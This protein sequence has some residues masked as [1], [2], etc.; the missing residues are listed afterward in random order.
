[1]IRVFPNAHQLPP[2]ISTTSFIQVKMPLLNLLFSLFALAVAFAASP[3]WAVPSDRRAHQPAN[4]VARA[5]MPIPSIA[6]GHHI[7]NRANEGNANNK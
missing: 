3:A 7:P 1:M 4:V 2:S 6:V 5:P